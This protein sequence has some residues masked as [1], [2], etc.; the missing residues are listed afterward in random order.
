[1]LCLLLQT[2]VGVVGKG[3]VSVTDEWKEKLIDN[4]LNFAGT[5][6]VSY[7]TRRGSNVQ[8]Q[9]LLHRLLKFFVLR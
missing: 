8:V 9:V 1:M 5:P 3:V 7:L 4:L 6:K 2:E